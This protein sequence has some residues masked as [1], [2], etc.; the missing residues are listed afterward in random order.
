MKTISDIE[1]LRRI[2]ARRVPR[3]FYD[4]V[5]S[6]SWTEQTYQLNQTSFKEILL[7]QRVG[8]SIDGR[9]LKSKMLGVDVSMPVAIA[10]IGL[11]GMVHADGEILAAKAAVAAGVRYTLSTLSIASLEDI[12]RATD[13]P[14]WFQLYVMRDKQFL[15]SLI[16]RAKAAGCDALILT[17]DLSVLGNRFKDAKNGLSTPPKLTISSLSNMLT[18]PKWCMGM[19][20]THRRNLGNIIGHAKGVGDVHS[21]SGWIGQQLNPALSWKDIEWIKA[22]WGGKLVVKGLLDAEDAQ[23]AVLAG[24]DAIIVSNHGGRQLDGAPASVA[25]LPEI[26]DKVGRATEVWIDGGIRSGQDV[27]KAIALGARGAL[28]G[29]AHLWGLGA[30]GEEGVKLALELIRKELDLTMAFC[31]HTDINSVD[32]SV[33]MERTIPRTDYCVA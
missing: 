8:R 19:L 7:R 21:L 28:I 11:A 27:L 29:R 17:L 3:M 18:K 15:L 23:T 32:R 16:D 13:A 33:L 5:D 31:G 2:A 6:G 14:F 24:A 25:V 1:D 22:R 26:V 10:P 30:Y 20:R 12:Q 4:F 9:S